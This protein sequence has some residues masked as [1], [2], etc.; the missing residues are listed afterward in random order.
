M[1]DIDRAVSMLQALPFTSKTIVDDT[2]Y[3]KVLSFLTLVFSTHTDLAPLQPHLVNIESACDLHD[4][5]VTAL[6]I[7]IL[8][9]YV[10]YSRDFQV[11]LEM[12]NLIKDGITSSEAALRCACLEAC[13][14]F[15]S[16]EQG[17][18]W[19]NQQDKI[20]ALALLD[21]S[22][23]VVAEACKLFTKILE[24]DDLLIKMDPSSMITSL[25]LPQADQRQILAALDFC[26]ELVSVKNDTA[27]KY[28][29]TRN[30]V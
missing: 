19:L 15:L 18:S 21:Q 29:R 2:L 16:C 6:S 30:L 11:S 28:I 9:Q 27:L 23:Y 3:E 26:W 5:R 20:I 13:R 24:L 7:R 22:S 14:L 1:R 25:L 8:G 12:L 10:H 17:Q 4:Y